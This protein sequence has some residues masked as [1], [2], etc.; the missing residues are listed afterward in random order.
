M[1]YDLLDVRPACLARG[2]VV[3]FFILDFY[4]ILVLVVVVVGPL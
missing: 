1:V 4:F 3:S 2:L